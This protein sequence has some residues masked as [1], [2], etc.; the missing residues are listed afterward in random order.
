MAPRITLVCHATTRDLRAATFGGDASLDEVGLGS[1]QKL[2]GALG[3]VDRCWTSPAARARETAA[4]LGL[5]PAVDDRLRDCDFGRWTGLKFG[6]VV[7][8]EPRKL[9]GWMKD[10]SGAP[11]GGETIPEV[12][13]RATAWLR[14]REREKGHTVAVTHAAVIRALIVQVIEARLNSFWRIDGVPRSM[15]DLRTNGRRWVLR[16]ISPAPPSAPAGC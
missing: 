8:K 12:M 10:P 2:I 4:A 15:T 3:R 7:L 11:H 6:Q 5:D 1:A 14:E 16:A 9:I 13:A